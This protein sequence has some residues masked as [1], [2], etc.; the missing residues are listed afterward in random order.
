MSQFFA[1]KEQQLSPTE[2]HTDGRPVELSP[3][4]LGLQADWQEDVAYDLG[5]GN[6]LLFDTTFGTNKYGVSDHCTLNT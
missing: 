4:L 6:A 1:Y 5:H 3:L 2:K